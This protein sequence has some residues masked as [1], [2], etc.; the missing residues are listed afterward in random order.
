MKSPELRHAK[1]MEIR[2]AHVKLILLKSMS[3]GSAS[4]IGLVLEMA[5][6]PDTAAT[7]A[8]ARR[9]RSF[10]RGICAGVCSGPS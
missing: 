6:S 4:L 1:L 7:M 9:G 5:G 2:S 10:L 8:N 3:P